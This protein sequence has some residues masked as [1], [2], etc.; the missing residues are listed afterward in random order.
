MSGFRK[1][2]GKCGEAD[3]D[4][5]DTAYRII[6]DHTRMLTVA[7]ADRIYPDNKYVLKL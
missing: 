5:I 2:S 3:I 1:Y 7:I 6:A 4:G